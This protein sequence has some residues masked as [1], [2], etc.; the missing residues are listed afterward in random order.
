VER[1]VYNIADDTGAIDDGVFFRCNGEGEL[2]VTKVRRAASELP[3]R[4]WGRA[5]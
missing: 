1:I 5:G 2:S 3:I 4:S